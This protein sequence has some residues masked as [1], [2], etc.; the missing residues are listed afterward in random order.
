MQRISSRK[1]PIPKTIL[2]KLF[3]IPSANSR[4]LVLIPLILECTIYWYLISSF[5]SPALPDHSDNRGNRAFMLKYIGIH[6][7]WLIP[8]YQ[9]TIICTLL[10]ILLT[11]GILSTHNFCSTPKTPTAR[12]WTLHNNLIQKL[13]HTGRHL[14]LQR[15]Q[16]QH[17]TYSLA[18]QKWWDYCHQYRTCWRSRITTQP[19]LPA[20]R[21][22][23]L[24]STQVIVMP[25]ICF[26]MIWYPLWYI[27][28]NLSL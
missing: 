7:D 16:N 20:H 5:A 21:K 28:K 27:F 12:H 6:V 14:N 2:T 11:I 24:L 26:S 18:Y 9:H 15:Q 17:N 1:P 25:M 8:W 19:R 13:E 10:R 4:S 3:I 23:L 22:K